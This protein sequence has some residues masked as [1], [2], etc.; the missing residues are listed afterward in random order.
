MRPALTLDLP[1]L[2]LLRPV[3]SG[4][5]GEVWLARTVTGQFRAVKIVWLRRPGET[6]SDARLEELGD[7][8]LR[9]V[10]EYLR[11]VS[12]GSSAGVA[13]LHVDRDPAG[14]FF[15]YVMELADD[16]TTGRDID[17][18]RYEP[19]T[20]GELRRRSPG[21][22]VGA[23]EV[24]RLGVKI[25]EGLATLHS[26]GL[27]HRDL[28][29]S[30]IVFFAGEPRLADI[31]LVRPSEASLSLGGVPGY[32]PPEGPGRPTGDVFSLARTLYVTVTGQPAGDFPRLPQDWDRRP[33]AD[34]LRRLNNVLLRA[35]D[36]DPKKRHPDGAALRDELALVAAGE[37]LEG[38]RR[39]KRI[40][41]GAMIVAA[42]AIPL[43]LVAA[44]VAWREREVRRDLQTAKDRVEAALYRSGLAEAASNLERLN[45][46]NA[47]RALARAKESS[48]HGIECELL[49]RQ[50]EG[51][52]SVQLQPLG[53]SVDQLV[54]SADGRW[55][56][57]STA[58]YRAHIFALPEGRPV[59][60][61]T[62]I[63]FLAGFL[64]PGHGLVGMSGNKGD[65]L[66]NRALRVWEMP[67]GRV[68]PSTLPGRCV[69]A[70]VHPDGRTVAAIPRSQL[71][72]VVRWRPSD[73]AG[74][75]TRS[76]NPA[77]RTGDDPYPKAVIAASGDR[78]FYRQNTGRNDT[79]TSQLYLAD[80][81]RG[82]AERLELPGRD[83]KVI[84]L[85]ADGS[86]TAYAD[87]STGEIVAGP[88]A[89]GL[90]GTA[91]TL[92]QGM[93]ALAF[94]ADGSRL[95]SGG[96]EQ[97]VRIH[98]GG[99][100]E[101]RQVLAGHQGSIAALAWSPDGT[102]L[103][104]G[105]NEGQVRLWDPAAMDAPEHR[106]V[107]PGFKKGVGQVQMVTDAEESLVAATAGTNS[108]VLLD[109]RTMRKVRDLEGLT[110]PLRFADGTDQLWALAPGGRLVLASTA[111]RGW[112]WQTNGFD[113]AVET[114]FGQASPDGRRLVLCSGQK[115]GLWAL[116][117]AVPHRIPVATAHAEGIID[118]AI[119]ADSRRAIT[120][121]RDDPPLLLDLVTGV[122]TPVPGLGEDEFYSA[123]FLPGSTWC[124]L[125]TR[126]RRLVRVDT[127]HPGRHEDLSSDLLTNYQLIASPDGR[128]LFAA[129]SGG[130]L[131]VVRASDG[132][133]LVWF[134]HRGLSSGPGEHTLKR[135]LYL[136]RQDHLLSL[137]EDGLLVRW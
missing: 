44:A 67:S 85:S 106:G 56:A 16:V 72:Q 12:P 130:R 121:A 111:G 35:C 36:S 3:G 90:R 112:L 133:P 77:L 31:D 86:R 96:S 58:D 127:A 114:A 117:E 48:D 23:A 34:A 62:N 38:R 128:R 33:D 122:A 60:T 136:S 124:V 22:K 89:T 63:V 37:D 88:A 125:G 134:T 24:V 68:L 57:V 21:Q 64:E 4:S 71:D 101:V 76:W 61:V 27:V 59:A 107:W 70:V 41:R 8:V 73:V 46:G 20:L 43:A 69:A 42:V 80:M 74:P 92:L 120:V 53:K 28:K 45:L 7:Q 17:P 13:V 113:T 40:A 19:L 104:S 131:G 119:S 95:A 108:I 52:T 116:D 29:P 105:D 32:A 103:A 83:I 132:E 51:D 84:T 50:A 98:D 137:T 99:T 100:L 47:R 9:G 93:T 54:F 135:L 49:G 39:L 110:I 126:T 109:A 26:A 14:R 102:R 1:G 115:I 97:L 87:P 2:T 55:L 30:N 25:A 18:E 15:Y 10:Q 5:F 6:E 129:G 11:R 79:Y 66:T 94:T 75:E 118:L 82:T 123:C 91:T 65:A 78:L 81:S